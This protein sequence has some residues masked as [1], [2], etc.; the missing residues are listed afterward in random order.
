MSDIHPFQVDKSSCIP[1]F[2]SIIVN[3]VN[4][5]YTVKN[6]VFSKKIMYMCKDKK[7]FKV[8]IHTFSAFIT[9]LAVC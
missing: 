8:K 1:H 4:Q 9:E 6:F 7:Y 3:M 2:M 5:D